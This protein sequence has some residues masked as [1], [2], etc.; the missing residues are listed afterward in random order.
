V[1]PDLGHDR[2]VV[3]RAAPDEHLDRLA[4]DAARP[5]DRLGGL[6]RQPAEQARDDDPGVVAVLAPREPRQVPGQ[7]PAEPPGAP[8]H[9]AG[10]HL[11]VREQCD[12][13]RRPQYR[14]FVGRVQCLFHASSHRTGGSDN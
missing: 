8:P 3:P 2:L 9:V 10:V 7:E 13:I 5:G 1:P 6:A 12:R 4:F 14:R 11:G